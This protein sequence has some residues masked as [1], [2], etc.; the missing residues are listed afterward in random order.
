MAEAPWPSVKK[1][2]TVQKSSRTETKQKSDGSI[3][4]KAKKGSTK[5]GVSVNPGAVLNILDALDS[6]GISK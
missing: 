2:W 4:T 6:L 3:V 5:V 1:D